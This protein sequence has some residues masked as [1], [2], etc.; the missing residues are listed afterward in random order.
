MKRALVIAR[1]DGLFCAAV[2]EGNTATDLYAESIAVPG[3]TSAVL[4]A[5]VTRTLPGQGAAIV[6][7]GKGQEG[8]WADAKKASAG[9][10]TTL[11]V[12]SDAWDGKLPQLT[13][14]IALT[15][16]FL[17]HLPQ[18]R[19]VKFSRRADRSAGARLSAGLPGGWIMRR[20]AGSASPE[21]L[22]AEA[23]ALLRQAENLRAA[24]NQAGV[25]LLRPAW[26]RAIADHGAQLKRIYCADF[27]IEKLLRAWLEDFA[28]DMLHIIRSESG[29]LDFD[30]LFEQIVAPAITLPQGVRLMI[31]PTR[32]LCVCDVDSGAM[33]NPLQANILAA[34]ALARQLRLRNLAGIIIV[35][36][37]SLRTAAERQKLLV[38]LRDAA[39]DD[40][41]GVEL[42]GMTKLG[43]VEMTRARYGPNIIELRRQTEL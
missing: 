31:E 34:R 24:D 10:W 14:D 6:T 12:K 25:I 15:G 30:S 27:V 38:A 29:G 4:R 20:H 32:A 26:R 40:P 35:D 13:A 37:I 42:F 16:R 3:L 43:L 22:Q 39:L 23:E 33:R 8:Y 7:W 41:A 18:G 11:Q 21:Q 5:K 9:D 1:H 2:T 36:F 17:I 28:P 19:G